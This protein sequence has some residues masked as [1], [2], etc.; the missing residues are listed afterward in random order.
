MDLKIIIAPLALSLIAAIAMAAMDK[1]QHHWAVSIFSQL[2]SWYNPKESWRL[3]WK[4]GDPAQGER[5]P[6]SSTV[7][8]FITD[9]WH[10]AKWVMLKAIFAAMA[11]ALYG[12][13][14]QRVVAFVVLHAAFSMGFEL[15]FRFVFQR[16][17]TVA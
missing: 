14:W 12:V 10:F 2:G 5:F 4:N 11:L 15:F 3:K 6:G 1:I 8:V 16:K 9:F 7:F 13:W 17:Q